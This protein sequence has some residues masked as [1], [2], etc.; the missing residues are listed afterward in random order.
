M[1]PT[2]C[3]SDFRWACPAGS[4]LVGY[5]E[6]SALACS[7]AFPDGQGREELSLANGLDHDIMYPGVVWFDS[8]QRTIRD[9]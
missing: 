2:E 4:Q 3:L 8:A 1:L 5:N 6:R 7:P 9:Y